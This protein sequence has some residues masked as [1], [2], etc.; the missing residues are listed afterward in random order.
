MIIESGL[1]IITG[2]VLIGIKLP[3]RT[4]LKM[5]GRPLMLDVFV[6]ILTFIMH[7][8][9]FSGVMAAAVAGVMCS[10]ITTAARKSFGYIEKDIYYK[11]F[12]TIS[13]EK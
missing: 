9:T 11:G 8:G 5:L 7:Y 13:L 3:R 10:L 12:F 4:A 2:L 6:T 1:I